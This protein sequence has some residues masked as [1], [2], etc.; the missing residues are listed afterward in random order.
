MLASRVMRYLAVETTFRTEIALV[1]LKGR[2]V[3]KDVEGSEGGSLVV[4]W[5]QA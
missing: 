2:N 4:R 5:R 1:G 3:V